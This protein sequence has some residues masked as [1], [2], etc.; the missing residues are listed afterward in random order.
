MEIP[1]ESYLKDLLERRQNGMIKIITG[2]SH[3]GKTYLLFKLFY[4]C[5]L[6]NGVPEDHILKLSLSDESEW[7][8]RNYDEVMPWI[9][10]QIKDGK[11]YYLLADEIHLFNDGPAV[12]NSCQHIGNLDIYA[13]DRDLNL[14]TKL[15]TEYSGRWEVIHVSPLSFAEFLPT[16]NMPEKQALDEYL[17]YG[18]MPYL[19]VCESEKQKSSFCLSFYKRVTCKKSSELIISI[20]LMT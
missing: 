10:S 12:L 16:C 6:E 3:S 1:R 9:K 14:F 4:K 5:L 11:P 20:V 8:L 19:S 7:S 17:R 15:N 18:G 2:L 13:V